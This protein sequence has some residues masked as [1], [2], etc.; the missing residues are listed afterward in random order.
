MNMIYERCSV[1]LTVSFRN[2]H[3]TALKTYK[4]SLIICALLRI[5]DKLVS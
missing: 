3:M 1:T 4:L 2:C 5:C